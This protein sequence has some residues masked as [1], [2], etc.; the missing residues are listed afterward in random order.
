MKSS[1]I[2]RFIFL[3]TLVF[4]SSPSNFIFSQQINF[5]SD[6][7]YTYIQHLSETIG[8]RPMGSVKEHQALEWVVQK[9]KSFGA[10]SAY[11]MRFTKTKS[12]NT[13]SGIAIGLFRGTTDST[14]VIGGHVD[15]AGPEIP[16]ANDNAS[17]TATMLELARIWST[18]DRHYTML[19]VTFGGE[20]QGLC[21]SKYFVKH[22]PDTNA[23]ALMFSLDMTGAGDEIIAMIETDSV[24]SPRWLVED[25]FEADATLG[26]DLLVYPT[27]FANL[28]SAPG[29]GPGSD[30]EPFIDRKIP[31]LDFTTGINSSPIHSPQDDMNFIDRTMLDKNGRLV[32]HLLMKYQ[33]EGIPH[34]RNA[35]FVLWEVAGNLIFIPEWLIIGLIWLAGILAIGAF[36]Y[37]HSRRLKIPKS[38]RIKL[39]GFKL[40]L[41]MFIIAVFAQLG[42]MILQAVTGFRYAW[43][44]NLNAYLVFAALWALAGVWISL[45]ITR[46]WR[47]TP[48]ATAYIKRALII[49]LLLLILFSFATK[50]LAIYPALSLIFFSLAVI[51]PVPA[52]KIILS[53]LAPLPMSRLMFMEVFPFFARMFTYTGLTIGNYGMEI[54]F[55]FSIAIILLVYYVFVIF[56]FAALITDIPPI[57]SLFKKF[58]TIPTGLALL[59][60]MSGFGIYLATLPAYNE[61]WQPLIQV[62]AQYDLP[63]AKSKL[64]IIGNEYLYDVSVKS[65]SVQKIYNGNL[66]RDDLKQTFAADWIDMTGS[67]TRNSGE[68]DTVQVDWK[69]ISTRPW[70]RVDF[71]VK[72]DTLEIDSVASDLAFRHNKKNVSFSWYADPPETLN[73][74]ARLITP[75]GAQIIRKLKATY[76]ELPVPVEVNAKSGN[77]SYRTEVTL[78]DTLKTEK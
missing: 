75:P 17:G 22:Y 9:L 72:V 70:H 39:S 43:Q 51:I 77:V 37:A 33:K 55:A 68:K 36:L 29:D 19:F 7:T 56:I 50:R 58:R 18:R 13:N 26:I 41:F 35:K 6:S 44:I 65:D 14:I 49:M 25:A 23:I 1:N 24:Q 28:N 42:E 27:H 69:L 32:D 4:L 20:E 57:K 8:P 71:N 34:A 30:H 47:F 46:H 11:I 74:S 2:Y 31:A 59:L 76:I 60:I 38:E 12:L 40:W 15:S 61:K 54:V 48:D 3:L 73:V 63:K 16:G 45:Q 66:H 64:Q 21:G 5:N 78:T 10:D 67:E 52:L 53:L 62:K